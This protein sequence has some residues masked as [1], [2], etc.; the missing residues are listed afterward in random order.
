[1]LRGVSGNGKKCGR[2]G[3]PLGRS[4]G[5]DPEF[6]EHDGDEMVPVLEESPIQKIGELLE[7]GGPGAVAKAEGAV[8]VVDE[9][10]GRVHEEGQDVHQGQK[11]GEMALSVAEIML[12]TIAP[13]LQGLDMLVFDFP[14][15]AAGLGERDERAFG[16]RMIG[17]PGIVIEDLARFLVGDDK[18]EPV[19]Q[20][21]LVRVAE[22][23]I[24]H[25]PEGPALPDD[26][27][28]PLALG[29][30]LAFFEDDAVGSDLP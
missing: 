30:P 5:I 26:L 29:L 7:E 6:G 12:E 14:S 11:I 23:E 21:G 1:M 19:R 3:S 27:G 20:Q 22:R 15:C 17:D 25:E 13:D 8:A 9:L 24:G 10:E 16:D 4:A 18:F 2:A 28:D